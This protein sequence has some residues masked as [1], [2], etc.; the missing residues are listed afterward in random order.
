MGNRSIGDG[1]A[2]VVVTVW[3]GLRRTGRCGA[4]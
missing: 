3:T 1:H 2:D 4:S